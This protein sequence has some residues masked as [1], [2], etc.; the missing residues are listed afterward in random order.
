V[1]ISDAEVWNCG[2]DEPGH[3][4]NGGGISIEG[5]V[6]NPAIPDLQDRRC[7]V[8]RARVRDCWN[9]GLHISAV[10]AILE[11]STITGTRQPQRRAN[12]IG[13]Y[14]SNIIVFGPGTLKVSR[15]TLS[16]SAR[17]GI[18]MRVS[19]GQRPSLDFQG[20]ISR[21]LGSGIFAAGV[22]RIDVRDGSVIA[23]CGSSLKDAGLFVENVVT[24]SHGDD[25]VDIAGTISGSAGPAVNADTVASLNLHDIRFDGNFRL[26]PSQANPVRL[27]RI[28]DLRAAR[29]SLDKANGDAARFIGQT[30]P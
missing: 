10:G 16:A 19:L 11:A 2:N 22:A 18:A 17:H 12:R 21:A 24:S 23:D 20:T 26:A 29:V 1:T 27:L 30:A 8:V 14:G 5:N 9:Q 13:F 4:N 28:R 15:S 25:V 6:G 3:P 7:I